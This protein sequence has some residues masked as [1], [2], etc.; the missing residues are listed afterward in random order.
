MRPCFLDVSNPQFLFLVASCYTSSQGMEA[1]LNSIRLITSSLDADVY[2][3]FWI[4]RSVGTVEGATSTLGHRSGGLRIA[5]L[6][7]YVNASG[8]R[9]WK[10]IRCLLHFKGSLQASR[11]GL[12]LWSERQM[13]RQ[14]DGRLLSQ[15]YKPGCTGVHRT[16]S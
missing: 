15:V 7:L 14:V 4:N 8:R 13:Q 6:A 9:F 3:G 5:F 1:E 10:L 11:D 2:R 16:F 12:H